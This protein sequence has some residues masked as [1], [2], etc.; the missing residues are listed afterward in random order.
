[1]S[2]IGRTAQKVS[3]FLLGSNAPYRK[4]ARTLDLRIKTPGYEHLSDNKE[5]RIA[6]ARSLSNSDILRK[7]P[8]VVEELLGA[9]TNVSVKVREMSGPIN[10][11]LI[12]TSRY[13]RKTTIITITGFVLSL[14]G[15]CYRV[16]NLIYFD[17]PLVLR[18]TGQEKFIDEYTS[19]R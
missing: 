9:S 1:M 11:G 3:T 2:F 4:A 19:Y 10:D 18:F 13:Q 8:P 17:R 12:S 6:I 14:P 5:L 16:N 7:F 15:N